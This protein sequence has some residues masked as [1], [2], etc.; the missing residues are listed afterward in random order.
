MARPLTTPQPTSSV[1]NFLEPHVGAAALARPETTM[2]PMLVTPIL[3]QLPPSEDTAA[4]IPRRSVLR[5]FKL[6]QELD[7]TLQQLVRY[8]SD[9]AGTDLK[10]TEILCA[11]LKGIETALPQIER[12]AKGLG[13]LKRPKND[14]LNE[15]RHEDFLREIAK[16]FVAGMRGAKMM[17]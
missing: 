1:A 13:P 5:Q 16:R 9:A 12:E 7:Q 2:R 11:V 4:R 15:K 8:Y 3:Q 6:P 17:D 10:M 14:P